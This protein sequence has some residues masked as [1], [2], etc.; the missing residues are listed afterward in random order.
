MKDLR[1]DK[2]ISKSADFAIPVLEYLRALIHKACPLTQETIKWGFP[3]FDYKNEMLCSMAA[4]KEHCAFTLWKASLLKRNNALQLSERSAMGHLGKIRTIK[5]LPDD[6]ILISFIK[7]AMELNDKG[8]KM[9]NSKVSVKKSVVI[10]DYFKSVLKINP[11][12]KRIFDAFSPSHKREYVEWFNEAKTDITR[13][14]RISTALEWIT[15]GK[16]RN[17][18]YIKK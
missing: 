9:V 11:E 13:N 10:P 14:K 17:W 3:H 18:K 5:D 6:K 12:A 1:I 16:S 7:E 2:Y 15:E 4:F 8:I